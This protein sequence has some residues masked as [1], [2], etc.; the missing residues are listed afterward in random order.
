M[1]SRFE[2]CGLNQMYSQRYGTRAAR[3]GDRRPRR[4]GRELRPG[5][6]Q[7]TGFKF[8]RYRPAALLDTLRWAL[9]VYAQ[10]RRVA[11][12][13]RAGMRKDFSWARRGGRTRRSTA[14]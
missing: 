3:A 14:R 5:D 11:R 8:D 10:P 6:G 13:Q 9:A 12:L 7:G 4:H 2:P 1:P